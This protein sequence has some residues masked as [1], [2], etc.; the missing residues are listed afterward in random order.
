MINRK[1]NKIKNMRSNI[2]LIKDST[3]YYRDI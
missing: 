2:Y 1:I 3:K